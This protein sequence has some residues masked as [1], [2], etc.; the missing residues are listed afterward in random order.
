MCDCNSSDA[1]SNREKAL[2]YARGTFS[3]SQHEKQGIDVNE[4]LNTAE[5]IL[6]F[7]EGDEYVEQLE[8]PLDR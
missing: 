6:V 8:L 1:R 5:S 3:Y 4:L 7:L 2:D